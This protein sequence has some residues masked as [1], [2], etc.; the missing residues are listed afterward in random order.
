TQKIL[1]A[2]DRVSDDLYV[3][4]N[5]DALTARGVEIF[6]L[7]GSH[8]WVAYDVPGTGTKLPGLRTYIVPN[9]GHARAG[10]PAAPGNDVDAAFFAE[11]LAGAGRGLETPEIATMVDGDMLEV[12]V[13]FPD[14]GVPEESRVFWMYDRGPDGSAWY[15]YDLFPDDHWAIMSGTG[16][17]WTATIPIEAGRAS[18]DIVTTHTV[19][20]DGRVVPISAP[21]TRVSI[22]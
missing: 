3:S 1:D 11:Q 5:W 7:P 20:V 22:D 21:Y 16:S 9:G 6:S 4:E 17:V 2:I 15:L 8:D 14:G 19:K 10:H 18:I 12:T 13:T